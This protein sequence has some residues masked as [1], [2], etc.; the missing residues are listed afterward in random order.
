MEQVPSSRGSFLPGS[1]NKGPAPRPW[2]GWRSSKTAYEFCLHT[3][4]C[5]KWADKPFALPF[6]KHPGNI[7]VPNIVYLPV[8]DLQK[9]TQK[10]YPQD[11]KCVP[12]GMKVGMPTLWWEKGTVAQLLGRS[13]T[14][15]GPGMLTKHPS[16]VGLRGPR[17]GL[18]PL[19]GGDHRGSGGHH[20]SSPASTISS[21]WASV[22]SSV[23]QEECSRSDFSK[24]H[25]CS[26]TLTI[27]V[28]YTCQLYYWHSTLHRLYWT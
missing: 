17:P 16:R 8:S 20:A 15:Q 26:S 14:N 10:L 2:W 23:K 22:S 27:F 24:R 13:S 6:P 19:R 12:G 28:I 11:G 9:K 18:Y 1:G 4:L 7:E 25:S 3:L 21:I 5:V